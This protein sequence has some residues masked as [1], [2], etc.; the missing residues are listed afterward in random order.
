V[1]P[2]VESF[3]QQFVGTGRKRRRVTENPIHRSDFALDLARIRAFNY[4][5]FG[6]F[7]TVD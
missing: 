1:V 5:D 3:D 4:D 7:G 2:V 6:V